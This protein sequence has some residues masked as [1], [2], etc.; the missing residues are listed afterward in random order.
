MYLH[1]KKYMN[2][3]I[4]VKVRREDALCTKC[5]AKKSFY[6]LTDFSYGESLVQT[7]DSKYCAY[8]NLIEDEV[9]DELEKYIKLILQSNK[10]NLSEKI[11]GKCLNNLFGIT[12]DA[13]KDELVDTA[14]RDDRCLSCGNSDFGQN[15]Y[16]GVEDI[17][18]PIVTHTAWSKL[19][20]YEKMSIIKEELKKQNYL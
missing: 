4:T 7:S 18:L 19:N 6:Y 16:E 17:E 9:F 20:E 10:L 8:V 5:G 11:F 14:S 2:S 12:C 15:I 3:T 13:I 1:V